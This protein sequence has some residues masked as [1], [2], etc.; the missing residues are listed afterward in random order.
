M[1][2]VRTLIVI[3]FCRK[4][5]HRHIWWYGPLKCHW[6]F[7]SFTRFI[8]LC[9]PLF[10]W[11]ISWNFK[12][13]LSIFWP[14]RR[15]ERTSWHSGFAFFRQFYSCKRVIPVLLHF[16]RKNFLYKSISLLLSLFQ[17]IL[18]NLKRSTSV[19]IIYWAKN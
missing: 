18:W 8:F 11:L 12:L 14:G 5:H 15:F 1:C 19:N 10:F 9:S 2:K 4:P 6:N 7:W 13:F 3:N 17:S 16:Q